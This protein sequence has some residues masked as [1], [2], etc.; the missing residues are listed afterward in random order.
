MTKHLQYILYLVLAE[1]LDNYTNNPHKEGIVMN[2][3]AKKRKISL[4]FSRLENKLA[5]LEATLV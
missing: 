1:S 3:I 5:S 4:P 2:I